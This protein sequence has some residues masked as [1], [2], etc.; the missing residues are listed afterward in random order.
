MANT[1]L[2]VSFFLPTS[3]ISR[4][5]DCI[6]A[7]KTVLEGEHKARDFFT[8]I[9]G[10]YKDTDEGPNGKAERSP[11]LGRRAGN[12][13]GKSDSSGGDSTGTGDGSDGGTGDA[14]KRGRGRPRKSE[15]GAGAATGERGGDER[16]TEAAGGSEA[17]QRTEFVRTRQGSDEGAWESESRGGSSTGSRD[18]QRRDRETPRIS[19]GEDR[20]DGGDDWGDDW[21]SGG[22]LS[23]EEA[24][25]LPGD[26]WPDNL[27]PKNL[28]KTQMSAILGDHYRATG[29]KDRGPTMAII[30][31][32][33]GTPQLSQVPEKLFVDIAKA[34]LKDT[35]RYELGLKR[36]K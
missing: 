27:T 26:E 29:G 6:A 20:G 18:D 8:Q 12:D 19:T 28:D 30:E 16:R 10:P 34:V 14:P 5:G 4:V 36:P 23:V 13:D 32:I 1:K 9:E 21:G 22:D 25:N 3:S 35:A 24:V 17:T 31:R 15:A 11:E 7:L 33:A 2:T